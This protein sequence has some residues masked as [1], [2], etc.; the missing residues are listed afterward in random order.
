MERDEFVKGL[1]HHFNIDNIIKF[2]DESVWIISRTYV[3][4]IFTFDDYLHEKFGEYEEERGMSMA[5]L[6][7]KEYSVDAK[8]WVENAIKNK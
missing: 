6:I 4:N 7:E 1:K 3:L 5:N 8:I 2:T